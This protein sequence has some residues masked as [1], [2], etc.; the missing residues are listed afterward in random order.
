MKCIK[1]NLYTIATTAVTNNGRDSPIIGLITVVVF[2]IGT[3]SEK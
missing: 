1:E 2:N 3:V